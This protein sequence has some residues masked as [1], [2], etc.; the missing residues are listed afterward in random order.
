MAQ[1][2][3]ISPNIQDDDWTPGWSP[4]GK[5]ITFVSDREGNDDI[6]VMDADGTNI[7]NI[8]KHEDDDWTPDWS[9]DGSKDCFTYVRP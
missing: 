4:D 8:T 7:V 3:S 5:K 6:Y 2:S 1:I 9:P